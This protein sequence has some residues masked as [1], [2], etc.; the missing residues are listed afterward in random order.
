MEITKP[1]ITKH[2]FTNQK[3]CT[4]T[5]NIHKKLKPG[6]VD[7]YDIWPQNGEGLF[8]FLCFKFVTHLLT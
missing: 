3:K 5:Q 4:T 6:L 8:L 7:S 1:N 2:T